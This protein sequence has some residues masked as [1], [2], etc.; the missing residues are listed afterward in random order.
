MFSVKDGDRGSLIT[1]FSL[2]KGKNEVHEIIMLSLL[3]NY[4]NC[5]SFIEKLVRYY[6][7]TGF[8]FVFF[9]IFSFI[10]AVLKCWHP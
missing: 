1:C 5:I 6:L 2:L 4:L 3:S 7:G 9:T 10:V 8:Y